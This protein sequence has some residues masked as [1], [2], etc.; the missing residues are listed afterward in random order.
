MYVL[1]PQH[2]HTHTHTGQ[3]YPKSHWLMAHPN[4]PTTLVETGGKVDASD[5]P[6]RSQPFQ[7]PAATIQEPPLEQI[8]QPDRETQVAN[9]WIQSEA[10]V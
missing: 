9:K 4:N 1:P 7:K 5:C 8:A 2:K 10:R 6:G 3:N